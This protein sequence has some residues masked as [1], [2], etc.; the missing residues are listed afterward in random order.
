[1]NLRDISN[2][3]YEAVTGKK[4]RTPITAYM[5]G[6]AAL[7]RTEAR[8][9]AEDALRAKE[10]EQTS[11]LATK[12]LEQ[13][14]ALAAKELEQSASQF[15]QSLAQTAKNFDS[16]MAMEAERLAEQNKQAKTSSQIGLANLGV[17]AAYVGNKLG[18][19]GSADTATAPAVTKA[20]SSIGDQY[21]NLFGAKKIA[22]APELLPEGFSAG[23][24][25]GG[26]LAGGEAAI[27]PTGTLGEPLVA[28]SGL[29]LSGA[30]A[31]EVAATTPTSSMSGYVAPLAY[32]AAAEMVRG[33]Q[34]QL[35]RE[36]EDRGAFAKMASAPVTGGPAAL[37]EAIAPD[38]SGN[39]F[40]KPITA[41]AKAEEQLVGQPLDKFF[42]G[43]IGGGISAAIGAV[44]EAP[45]AFVETIIGGGK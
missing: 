35:D 32:I 20:A 22:A 1:M 2:V 23:A 8:Q 40:V 16:E 29:A 10:L 7:S 14:S 45:K 19:F 41:V 33:N 37:V 13:T 24:E 36:Y 5:L 26:A 15:N 4:R 25:A 18:W 30:E 31:G 39:A 11:A 9:K 38:S 34:G 28:D 12:E 6:Q 42:E 21:V 44:V 27:Y 43:D 17:T 3:Q